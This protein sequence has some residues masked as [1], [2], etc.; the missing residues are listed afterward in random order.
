MFRKKSAKEKIR[1]TTDEEF[2]IFKLVIDKYLWIGTV[3]LV[4][5]VFLLL[6]PSVDAG[7]G[8]LTTLIGGVILLLFTAI[9][10]REFDFNRRR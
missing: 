6:N 2:Q 1:L 4:Y 3:S 7:Y 10:F 5:G 8:L 9:M